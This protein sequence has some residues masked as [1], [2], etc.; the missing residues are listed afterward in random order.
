MFG[1]YDKFPKFLFALTLQNEN[2]DWY[3]CMEKF[4]VSIQGPIDLV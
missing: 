4:E 1:K 3:D 2:L